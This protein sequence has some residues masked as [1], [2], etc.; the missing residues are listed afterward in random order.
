MALDKIEEGTNSS[1]SA[2]LSGCCSLSLPSSGVS[3]LSENT[4]K[5]STSLGH[6]HQKSIYLSGDAR[7]SF[8]WGYREKSL[9]VGK[10]HKSV[11]RCSKELEITG[12]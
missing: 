7:V 10:C 12:R 6:K 8:K 11:V 1:S 9:I 2:S 5:S 4:A 3:R